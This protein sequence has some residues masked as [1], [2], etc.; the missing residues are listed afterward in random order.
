MDHMEIVA[1]A[2]TVAYAAG[3]AYLDRYYDG[4]DHGACGFAWVTIYPKHKGNTK[5]GKEERRILREMGFELDWTGKRF[6]WWNPSGLPVQNIE[7]K[8]VGAQAAADLL[9]T[10][11]F[12]AF[13]G[14]RLD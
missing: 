9:K 7:A 13:S 10:H 5:A 4:E 8:H 11:G 6:E 14:C 3:K 1:K 2:K 12:T